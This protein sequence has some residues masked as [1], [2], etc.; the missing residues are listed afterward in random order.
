[1][2][3]LIVKHDDRATA[4]DNALVEILD[5]GVLRGGLRPEHRCQLFR[6]VLPAVLALVELLHVRQIKRAERACPLAFA[7]HV[8]LEIV[9]IDFHLRRNDRIGAEDATSLEI[10]PQ[11][12]EHDHVRRDQEEGFG[13]IVARLRHRIEELPGDRKRHDFRL[14]ASR[15]HLHA[16]AREIVVLQ[17]AQIAPSGEGLDQALVPPHLGDF[18]E[19]DQ[20]LDGFALE[21]M[22]GEL[23][24]VRQPVVGIEPIVQ[25]DACGVGDPLVAAFAPRFDLFADAG[26]QW[27][28][29]HARFQQTELIRV[30][31]SFARHDTSRSRYSH[32]PP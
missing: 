12:L 20:R 6:L 30:F 7:A 26:H 32:P 17:Q 10:R 27:R 21:I 19:I 31:F 18:V 23:P 11:P 16:V 29:G 3:G 15:R 28:R 22:V 5:P 1:M 13:E 8:A 24:A 25:Q 14:A 2:V 9:P 4:V